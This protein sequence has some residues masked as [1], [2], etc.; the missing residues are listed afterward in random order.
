MAGRLLPWRLP[1]ADRRLSRIRSIKRSRRV[2][3]KMLITLAGARSFAVF[4]FSFFFFF[5]FFFFLFRVRGLHGERANRTN[6][7][8]HAQLHLE[9]RRGYF[10][11]IKSITQ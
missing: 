10:V 1:R 8:G 11:S 3:M 5:F 4:S 6:L 2:S 9:R 7:S